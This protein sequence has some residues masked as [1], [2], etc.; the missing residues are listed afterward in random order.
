MPVL[1]IKRKMVLL[2]LITLI[3]IF[4]LEIVR[5]NKDFKEKV[6]MELRAGED[7]ANSVTSSFCNYIEELWT[8]QAAIGKLFVSNSMTADD[9]QKYLTEVETD[10]V[11]FSEL[12]WISADG[13]IIASQDP[14]LAG[15]SVSGI[16]YFSRISEGETKVLTGLIPLD[17]Q[18]GH[19]TYV[20]RGIMTDGTLHGIVAGRVYP[21]MFADRLNMHDNSY[22]RDFGFIDRKGNVLCISPV[23]STAV[24]SS[25]VTVID[26][27]IPGGTSNTSIEY[28]VG[29][30]GWKCFVSIN[31]EMIAD[32][33][34]ASLT[35][36]ITVL[37]LVLI[38]SI[39]LALVL[40]KRILDPLTNIK[41]TI[42]AVKS[43]NYTVRSNIYG[44][45]EVAATAQDI[46][47]MVD[48]ILTNDLIKSQ[49][50][51]DLSHELKA[52]LNVIYASSQLIESIPSE[53]C[54]CE[55][56]NKVLKYCRSIR[57]NCYKLI[58]I[59]SNLLDV[60]KYEGG[61]LTIR[62]EYLNIISIIEE[63]TMSVVA[64]AENKGVSI[65]FDTDTEE[66]YTACDQNAIERII[67]NLLSNA[68]KFTDSGGSIFVSIASTV[69]RIIVRVDD[70]GIGIP[71]DKLKH[72][73]DRFRQADLSLSRNYYGS[74]LGLSL[75][76]TL[77][78]VHKGTIYVTS[79]EGKGTSFILHLPVRKL[80]EE[81]LAVL[82]SR[83]EI[84]GEQSLAG[85]VSIE[86]SDI[87]D[88]TGR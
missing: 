31:Y 43:G 4:L 14:E 24:D 35:Y 88:I 63:T 1:T 22:S 83:D 19:F 51:T 25:L 12:S 6:N 26:E 84:K 60:S 28:P 87:N 39:L 67:L 52:P 49:A 13:T 34:N 73:F 69:D 50:F 41:E 48:T 42:S 65:I 56:H 66:K 9:I 76:K 45:D 62:M 15:T 85:K 29:L 5:I 3:P 10:D 54:T 81:E 17:S 80:S 82:D 74:G 11:V 18:T 46:D 33:H 23:K 75:V 64:Y 8:S 30:S 59:I 86:L 36:N 37:L 21:D 68:L 27:S 79:E 72:V 16:E 40:A 57:L 58:K 53:S 20:A 71:K 77:V 7:L 61:H 55:N 47:V 70:T 78:E 32:K 38:I 44:N 2:V